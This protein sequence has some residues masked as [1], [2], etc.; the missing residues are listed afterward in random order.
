MELSQE[1]PGQGLLTTCFSTRWLVMY[2]C[3]NRLS[4]SSGRL[5]FDMTVVYM[6]AG[7]WSPVV[8]VVHREAVH[9]LG[10]RLHKG[11]WHCP[12]NTQMFRELS[13]L[14]NEG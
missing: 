7:S 13:G 6:H 1:L 12:W 3:P 14:Q 5:E 11:E 2:V 10:G 9:L 4:E 8:P